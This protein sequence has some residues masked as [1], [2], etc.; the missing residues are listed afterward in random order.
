L[1]QAFIWLF[2]AL[3]ITPQLTNAQNTYARKGLLDLRKWDFAEEAVNL[4]GEWEFHMSE[5]LAPDKFALDTGAE[6]EYIDFPSTWNDVS[7]S[8]HPGEGFATY[9]LTVLIHSPQS[10]ALELP[11]FYSNYALWVNSKLIA[12]NGSV[13]TSDITSVPQWLPQTVT[14]GSTSDT[15]DIVI[16]A[17]NFHHAKGGVREEILLGLTD[18]LQLKRQ[19]AVVSTVFMFVVL[20]AISGVFVF[21]FFFSKKRTSMIYF[22]ALCITWAARSILSNLYV[23]TSFFPDLPW[24]LCVKIEYLSLYLMMMWAIL[25]LASIF[26]NDVS[27]TFKY[28]ICICNGVFILL[29]L[30]FKASLYTQFLPV[31]LSFVTILLLYVIYILIRAIVGERQGVWLLVTCAFLGVILFSYD[32]ISYE[33]FAIF[34]PVILN[35]G[36]II[37]FVLMAITLLMHTGYLKKSVRSANMLTYEE[38][39]GPSKEEVKH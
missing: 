1:K 2:A 18:S 38:L 9:R 17:S 22:A 39:F 16:H 23:A 3:L 19:V 4:T 8:L 24:E 34:N 35:F 21:L 13:G 33:G 32:L 29:T 30:F 5:L 31:Y 10:L 27:S 26:R 6:K 14:L 7:K 37:M 25:F 36:Y 11:H 12:S 28:F 20:I 15:L